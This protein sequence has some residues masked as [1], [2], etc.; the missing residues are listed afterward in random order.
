[1]AQANARTRLEQIMELE[2]VL[3][4][5]AEQVIRVTS[6]AQ[7][8]E[9]FGAVLENS[10]GTLKTFEMSRPAGQQWLAEFFGTLRLDLDGVAL[11]FRR[12]RVVEEQEGPQL[13]LTL[14]VCARAFPSMEV[15]F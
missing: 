15:N 7:I 9:G 10:Q 2:R 3:A 8:L 14:D 6:S 13:K 1:M 11:S 4:A 12:L 5:D